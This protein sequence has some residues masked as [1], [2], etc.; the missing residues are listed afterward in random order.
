LDRA[1]GRPSQQSEVKVMSFQEECNRA[2]L[3]ALIEVARKRRLEEGHSIEMAD[4]AE[5]HQ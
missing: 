2:H 1:L 4:D 5:R 3:A